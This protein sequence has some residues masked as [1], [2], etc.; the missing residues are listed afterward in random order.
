MKIDGAFNSLRFASHKDINKG[1]DVITL[2][3][4]NI[5]IQGLNPKLTKGIINSLSGILDDPRHYQTSVQVQP[6]NSGGALVDKNGHIIG[7]IDAAISEE[8]V[9]KMSGSLP[10]NINYALKGAYI[11]AFLDTVEGLRRKLDSQKTYSSENI[12]QYLENSTALIFAY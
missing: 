5:L 2:G 9:L 3:Y 7:M 10:Q 1:E 12:V 11:L 6:G 4:P 8:A